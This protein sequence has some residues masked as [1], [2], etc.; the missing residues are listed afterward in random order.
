MLKI[1]ISNDDGVEAKGL[2]YLYDA[3]KGIA[4]VFVIAPDK[5]QSGAGSSITTKRPLKTQDFKENFLSVNG[6]PADCVFLGLNGLCPFEPDLVVS[7]INAGANMGEDLLYS[8]T[9]GAAMEGRNT[10]LPCI[11]FSSAY[12]KELDQE[13]LPNYLSAALIAKKLIKNINSLSINPSVTLNV[14]VPN[15][16][17]KDLKGIK[18]TV[19]GSWGPRNPPSIEVKKSGE[20]RFW[21]THRDKHSNNHS[22][23]DIET[24][25]KGYVSVTPVHP[26]FLDVGDSNLIS[27]LQI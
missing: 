8:G 7:G 12:K 14:N 18:N 17:F 11:A 21:I 13:I 9:I 20:K 1:L 25:S 24:L 27:W 5:N 3:L 19:L 16:A 4:N 15:L 2:Q 23:T 10:R 22:N 26:N 6:T